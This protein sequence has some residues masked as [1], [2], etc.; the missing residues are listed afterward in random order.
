MKTQLY[1]LT[2]KIKLYSTKLMAI[3]LSF[4]LPIVGILILIAASVILDT[5]T[6]I[7]K[8]K[9]LK[10]PITSRRLSAIISKILLYEATVMLFFTMDKFLLNDIVSSFFSIDLLTTK[11]LALV[12][13]SIEVISINENYY[14]IYQKD[15]WDAL[16]NLFA[17]AKEV[18]SDFKNIKKN[19]DL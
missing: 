5:I 16:K 13:V 18:T 15:L 10:Q 17:R 19:E 2:T 11:V 1:I 8:S 3:I 6:G 12:L 7:W 14:A 4:F 9:K